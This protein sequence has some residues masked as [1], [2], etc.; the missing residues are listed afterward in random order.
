[1]PP[2]RGC[3]KAAHDVRSA[4]QQGGTRD[5]TVYARES[6]EMTRTRCCVA[7]IS[8]I[9]QGHEIKNR[10]ITSRFRL[11][12][13]FKPHF[14]GHG[15]TH[16]E[17]FH[18]SPTRWGLYSHH[19]SGAA[20]FPLTTMLEYHEEKNSFKHPFSK[21]FKEKNQQPVN[22]KYYGWHGTQTD[23]AGKGAAAATALTVLPL[24]FLW[25]TQC[26][27]MCWWMGETRT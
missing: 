7:H 17:T 25:C 27:P 22:S 10:W 4:A 8:K 11:I 2:P 20:A 18:S 19:W 1:M 13:H 12:F 23:H 3:W 21:K 9:R 6:R 5:P 14:H 24:T 15:F 26:S 16:L